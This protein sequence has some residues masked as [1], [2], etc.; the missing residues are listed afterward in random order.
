MKRQNI[1]TRLHG[2]PH[3]FRATHRFHHIVSAAIRGR[4]RFPRHKNGA[5]RKR[6]LHQPLDSVS[7]QLSTGLSTLSVG[8]ST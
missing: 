7:R 6:V 5:Q 8:N 2:K 4:K 1:D 3:A